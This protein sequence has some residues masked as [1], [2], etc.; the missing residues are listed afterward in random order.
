MEKLFEKL[1]EAAKNNRKGFNRLKDAVVTCEQFELAA[2]LR[3]LEIKTFPDTEEVKL[4]K[5]QA[6]KLNVLFRMVDLNIKEDICWLINETLKMNNEMR[7][8]FSIDDAVELMLK[9][10]RIFLIE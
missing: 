8:E 6:R 3:Q 4:A 1:I 2:K 5:E 7:G 9:K 10:E